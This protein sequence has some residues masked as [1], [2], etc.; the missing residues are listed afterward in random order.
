MNFMDR[1]KPVGLLLLRCALA[2]V[3]I[4]HGYQKYT[5]GIAAVKAYMTGMGLPSYFAFI[6]IGLEIG[7][8]ALLLAGLAT[9]P[10]AILLAG[11]MVVAIAK[12]HLGHGITAVPQYEFA[13]VCG[14]ACFALA[15]MGA[16]SA[17]LDAM[18]FGRGGRAK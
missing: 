1:L 6:S 14:A 10:I 9:R 13:M 8:G 17:S 3:F 12:A 5:Y 18:L 7:G 11:E 15:T 2:V 16:G 4:Y